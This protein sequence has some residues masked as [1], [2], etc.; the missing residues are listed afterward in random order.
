MWQRKASV[1]IRVRR[2]GGSRVETFRRYFHGIDKNCFNRSLR[3]R[4]ARFV[5]GG[6]R[7]VNSHPFELTSLASD[8]SS[9]LMEIFLGV[10]CLGEGCFLTSMVRVPFSYL[11]SILEKSVF[12]GMRSAR[13]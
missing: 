4:L 6:L 10:G 5:C 2:L 12:S 9:H 8:S 3:R 13:C 11:D 1:G 7:G